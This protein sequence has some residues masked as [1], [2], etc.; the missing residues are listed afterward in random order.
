MTKGSD[1]I[2]TG[3]ILDQILEWKRTEVASSK[4][5]RPLA[6]VQAAAA[7]AAPP[8][9]LAAALRAPGVSLIAEIKRASPS[10]G[11]LRGDLDPRALASTYADSG[12]SAISVLTDARFFRG[13]L[14]DLCE[15]RQ[16]TDLPLLRKEFVLDAYQVYEARA[17]GADAVLLIVAALHDASLTKLYQLIRELGMSSLVEVHNE[18][19][20]QRA[21]AL[22]PQIVGINNR[23]LHTFT[24]SFDTTKDLCAQVPPGT[25]V[26]AESGIH[27]PADV[28]RLAAL[29]VH[30]M[31][32]GE[33]LVCA[34]DSGVKVR[35]LLEGNAQ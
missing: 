14:D 24:V 1:T 20:L 5:D 4:R 12:A 19:E 25:I 23:D 22:E 28:A 7:A 2:V 33:S 3:T 9:D 10:R 34:P 17:A 13:H 16:V 29:G 26:V 6:A 31:L 18:N 30:G 27:T 8:R 11:L 35:E 21:L 32:V 15:A